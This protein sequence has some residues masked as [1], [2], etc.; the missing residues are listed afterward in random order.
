MKKSL[1]LLMLLASFAGFSQAIS[2]NTT[3]YNPDQLVNEVL[4]SGQCNTAQGVVAQT[5]TNFGSVN[6][7]GY[8]ENTSNNPNF[9]FAKGVVLS[10]GDVTKIPGVNPATPNTT[11]LSDGNAAW[12]GDADLQNILLQ[13]GITFNSTNASFLKF[14]FVPVSANFSF[15][16]VF[17]SEEYG[18]LQCN[19]SDAFAFILTDNNTGISKNLALVNGSSPISVATI[20]NN[21]YNSTCPSVNPNFFGAYNGS[22]FGPAIN[23]NGQTIKMTASD[24]VDI[25]HTYTIKLVIADGVDSNNNPSPLYDSAV[26]FGANTFNI[27]SEVLGLDYTATNATATPPRDAICP[28]GIMPTLA[29]VTPLPAGTIYEWLK[30]GQPYSPAQTGPTLNLQAL[31]ENT[32]HTYTLH[33]T[34]QNC[35]PFDDSI[36]VEVYNPLFAPQPPNLFKSCEASNATHSF[37]LTPNT[38]FMMAGLPSDAIITYHATQNNANNNVS[39]L[40][41]TQVV[42]HAAAV[43]GVTIYARIQSGTSPCFETKSFLLKYTPDPVIN[44]PNMATPA[45]AAIFTKCASNY[46]TLPAR[47]NFN[48][49]QITPIILG[50]QD[51]T[52]YVVRYYISATNAQTGTSPLTNLNNQTTKDIFVRVELIG[53]PG[54]FVVLPA[55]APAFTITATPKA[56]IETLDDVVICS[57][58]AGYALPALTE[59]T[60]KYFTDTDGGGTELAVGA[61]INTTQEIFIYN[62]PGGN[63]CPNE[64]SFQVTKVN[65]TSWTQDIPSTP[66]CTQ[67]LLPE[68]PYGV[69]VPNDAAPGTGNVP[70]PAG[71]PI[72]TTTTLYVHVD[73]E[74]FTTA[75]FDRK[76]VSINIIPFTPIVDGDYPNQFNCNTYILGTNMPN[77]PQVTYWTGPNQTGTQKF[78][79]DP[80]TVNN[81]TIY[82]HQQSGPC[83]NDDVSFNVLTSLTPNPFPFN[84]GQTFNTCSNFT[85]PALTIGE[86]HTAPQSAGGGSVIPAGALTTAGQNVI[87]VYVPGQPCTYAPGGTDYK[88]TVNITLAPIPAIA[89]VPAQCDFYVLPSNPYGGP[90]GSKYYEGTYPNGVLVADNNNPNN[91]VVTGAGVHTFYLGKTQQTCHVEEYFTVTINDTP[92]VDIF[93]DAV[94]PCNSTTYTLPTLTHPGGFYN[95]PGGVDP[96]AGNTITQTTSGVRTIYVYQPGTTPGVCD[97]E[98]SFTVSFSIVDV[99]VVPNQY[100]CDDDFVLPAIP[101]NFGDYYDAPG[102]PAGTG[103]KLVMPYHVIRNVPGATETRTFYLYA[104]DGEPVPCRDETS[105]T[106]TQY[107]QPVI[108][109]FTDVNVCGSYTLPAYSS[110]S[111][112]PANAVNHYYTQPGG[113]GTELMPNDV[114]STTTPIYVYAGIIS[115]ENTVACYTEA[116]W[117]INITPYP[118]ITPAVADIAGCDQVILAP[119]TTGNYFSDAAHTTPITN[120]TLTTSQTVYVMAVNNPN[121][122][123]TTD[124]FDVNITTSPVLSVSDPV[125][126]DTTLEV[127][128]QYIL[129]AYNDAMFTVSTGSVDHYFLSSG[130]EVFPGNAIN[131]SDV[132]TI[133]AH[134][135]TCANTTPVT[136][137]VNISATPILAPVTDLA[138]CDQVVLPAITVGNYYNDSAHTSQIT[139][140]TLTASQ[141][142]YVYA[143]SATN[144]N[145]NDSDTFNVNVTITPVLDPADYA[146]I[147]RCQPYILP[148]L[149]TPGAGYYTGPNGTGTQIAPGTEI[150]TT[151]TLFV[152][153]IN[154]TCAAPNEDKLISIYQVE[155]LPPYNGCDAYLLPALTTPNANYYTGQGGTGNMLTAGTSIDTTQTIYIFGTDPSGGCTSETSFIV[156][157]L[158]DAVANQVTDPALLIVC[159]SDANPDDFVTSIDLD[160]FTASVLGSQNPAD[161]TVTY[162]P[163][164]IDQ[165]MQTNAITTD[166][167]PAPDSAVN[168]VW[169]RIQNATG[170]NANTEILTNVVPQPHIDADL[171]GI[172]C[173]DPDT[174]EVT[175]AYIESGYPGGTGAGSYSFTWTDADDVVVA[176][177]P[178]LQTTEAGTYH[179][180]IRANGVNMCESAPIT[181]NIIES[182]RPASVNVTT[183]GWFTDHQT[184]TIE[185]IPY[186]GT[187]TANFVY[188]LD[189]QEPQTEAVFENVSGGVHEILVSDINGCGATP[190]PFSVE[191]VS[192]P[193]Y[194]T[195][196]GDGINDVWTLNG[197]NNIAPGSVSRIQIFDRYGKLVTQIT[198]NGPGWDGNIS[199][200]P[201]PADDYWFTLIYVDPLTGNPKEYKSHFSLVR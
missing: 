46:P 7:I 131:T 79:G 8:F 28:G 151:T 135:G 145:C 132:I 57:S 101:N 99:P 55:A 165:E 29:P 3:T 83:T 34:R 15:D 104:D 122:C 16:F 39:P 200:Q 63:I 152:Y 138:G 185:A 88:F 51:P 199:G 80:I 173:I 53:N 76:P 32:T 168:P 77:N 30:D 38:T 188:S 124:S 21:T 31:G 139:N 154:G 10:T 40:S 136:L 92:I 13:S 155:T 95:Q 153:A 190:A 167:T 56:P 164:F 170:C 12:T 123:E 137:T 191:L 144:P 14:N 27:G 134:N 37:D 25:T 128:D 113:L 142:V 106:V 111:T 195:P 159:D 65:L 119:L 43:A 143:E 109:A 2:V 26:F 84:N 69:Y 87:F 86:Y 196:N 184:I 180:V 62:N 121:N 118:V 192:S 73:S 98:D 182:A 1:F 54:C 148:A 81:T 97:A 22:G 44:T 78:F 193:T 89:D 125:D 66:I 126:G 108:N 74:G 64:S 140:L 110:F 166:G 58:S 117:N 36:I 158:A 194:F 114:I 94:A 160:K 162:Y 24:V 41:T 141:P 47:A 129:P 130:T 100:T 178:N 146:D 50:S 112:T 107:A 163:S 172:I 161:F 68:L 181:V 115:P 187:S 156:T 183:T 11:T 171:S 60:S 42:T 75:C 6:G 179:L 175:A 48:L 133:T 176:T 35:D 197:M 4:I 59:P 90:G 70:I 102:G 9:P 72:N 147:Y 23:F 127:C 82:L 150:S 33:Y 85:L 177:T 49:A 91:Y 116:V 45:V 93:A 19:F 61:L 157:K 67:F 198:S 18:A 149:I 174:G 103:T 5:G 20:R 186:I 120:L 105:F 17:A 189:G 52:A 96:I 71:S 169:A 201:L